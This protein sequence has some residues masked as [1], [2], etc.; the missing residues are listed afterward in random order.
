MKELIDV[1]EEPDHVPFLR[2]IEQG[3]VL[4]RRKA[5]D[6]SVYLSSATQIDA[7]DLDPARGDGPDGRFCS[8][9]KEFWDNDTCYFIARIRC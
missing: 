5:V 6:R 4:L 2:Q 8:Y 1:F 9:S 7:L 3:T